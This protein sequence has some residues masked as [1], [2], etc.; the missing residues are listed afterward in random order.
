MDGGPRG[1]RDEHIAALISIVGNLASK[2]NQLEGRLNRLTNTNGAA[3]D[4]EQDDPGTPA[5]WVWYDPP[6]AAEADPAGHLDP[7]TTVDDFVAFYNATFVGIEG[8]RAKRIPRCW[9]QHPGLAMEVAALAYSW[10]TANTGTSATIRDAQHWLHHWRPAFTDRLLR[11]WIHADCLDGQHRP[12]GA[13]T[14]EH[15]FH[16]NPT[17]TART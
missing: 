4:G 11:D 15:R 2:L 7:T 6:L 5:A 3:S 1:G 14:R 12:S 13:P 10:H 16:G 17:P 9:S 8:G